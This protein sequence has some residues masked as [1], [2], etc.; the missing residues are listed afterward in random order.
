M[1]IIL[2]YHSVLGGCFH[3]EKNPIMCSLFFRAIVQEN[4]NF[5]FRPCKLLGS[6]CAIDTCHIWDILVNSEH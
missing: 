4:Q 2:I 3:A 6:T 5:I 1:E